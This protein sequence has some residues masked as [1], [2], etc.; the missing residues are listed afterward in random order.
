MLDRR[1][2]DP[3][4]PAEFRRLPVELVERGS[5]KSLTNL[6]AVRSVLSVS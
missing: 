4:A 6:G 5:V 2:A 3:S 1:I